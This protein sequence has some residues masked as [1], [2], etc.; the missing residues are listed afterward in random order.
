MLA[1]EVY[2]RY[3]DVRREQAILDEIEASLRGTILKDL[4]ERG[5]DKDQRDDSTFAVVKK[6]SWEYTERVDK[7][8]EKVKIAKVKEQER[9][10]ATET[11]SESLRYTIKKGT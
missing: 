8:E 3:A 1:P 4:K 6:S 7:L 11:V 2:K 10:E 5:V 9:G